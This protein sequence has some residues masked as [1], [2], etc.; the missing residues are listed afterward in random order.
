MRKVRVKSKFE[1]EAEK[2]YINM[3]KKDGRILW[4]KEDEKI[5]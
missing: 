2:N 1:K 3:V 5:A 4:R